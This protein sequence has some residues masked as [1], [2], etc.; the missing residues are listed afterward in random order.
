M[1]LKQLT[2]LNGESGIEEKWN[3]NILET[4]FVDTDAV[5]KQILSKLE[6]SKPTTLP[7]W[8]R[9]GKTFE[10]DPGNERN[11]KTKTT[12]G[13]EIRENLWGK[14]SEG[15]QEYFEATNKQ[16]GELKLHTTIKQ[17]D[18]ENKVQQK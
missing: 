3:R 2:G 11:S 13:E 12:N 16:K 14:V 10:A 6:I 18:L 5:Q 17:T 9:N 4:M 7:K 15:I 8:T 1:N